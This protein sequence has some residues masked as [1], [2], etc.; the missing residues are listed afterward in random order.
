MERMTMENL[1]KK[2]EVTARQLSAYRHRTD[3]WLGLLTGVVFLIVVYLIA[4]AII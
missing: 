4:A 2:W 3:L 1:K